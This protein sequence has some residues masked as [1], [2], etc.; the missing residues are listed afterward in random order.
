MCLSK[1]I[2]IGNAFILKEKEAP[3]LEL[4]QNISLELEILDK[5]LDK[6][7]DDLKENLA[8]E[9][10][11]SPEQKTIM[12][13]HL[14]LLEDPA[15]KDQVAALI[16]EFS[17]RCEY[18]LYTGAGK[19]AEHF[20]AM[21]NAYFRERAADMMD[22]G[23]YVIE[24]I[25]SK[26]NPVV[27]D[28]IKSQQGLVGEDFG[29]VIVAKDLTPADTVKLN[30]SQ[31]AA[32]ITENGGPSSHT[33]IIA[34]SMDIPALSV[35][36]ISKLLNQGELV[37][38]DGFKGDIIIEPS[39]ATLDA[40]RKKIEHHQ[41]I[42]DKLTQYKE[43][44][45]ETLDGHRVKVT[46][47]I[48]APQIAEK[49]MEVG[50]DGIGLYRSEFLYMDRI[51]PPDEEIQFQIYKE[52]AEMLTG[53]E[54]IVR[55]LDVGGD[56][57]IDYLNIP[58]EDNPFLG[59]RAIRY[60]LGNTGIFKTQIRA[61][62]R[63]SHFGKIRIM[64]PMIGTYE[65][66]CQTKSIIENCKE[67]LKGNQ[68]PFD[69]NLKIGIMIEVPS[70]AMMSD[71]LAKE[72]DFFSIGTND[73]IAYT[74]AAD[75]MN[76]KV[77]YLYSD[78]QP[79]VLRLIQMTIDNGHKAGIPVSMCG[80]SAANPDLIPVYLG[81]GLDKF[82]VNPSEVLGVKEQIC[83]LKIEACRKI[84]QKILSCKSAKS[85]KKVIDGMT[86]SH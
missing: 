54:V 5:G 34:R 12:E 85:V 81:M 82:S 24:A 46:A 49:V 37:I 35:P 20:K 42:K 44:Q 73:L 50:A 57:H 78:T 86:I 70:A 23:W 9:D 53:K 26:E 72:V 41:S 52:V 17:Y 47:N 39:L 4:T 27:K 62:L 83:S 51:S 40:Y 61:L 18:A 13:T 36:D 38:V 77:A 80:N 15:F 29:R 31:V 74:M 45:A 10:R 64:I 1:G 55:T 48:V 68:I 60:C 16:K 32:F 33:A 76:Q 3:V 11:M 8:D 67:E 19:L 7:L 22:L 21:D 2:A 66:W 59:F 63:A 30:M 71:I 84:S 69:D 56:K 75:R 79:A 25:T 28:K 65:E 6:A 58:H 43:C 14:M